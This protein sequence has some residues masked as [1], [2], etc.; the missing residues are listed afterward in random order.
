MNVKKYMSKKIIFLSGPMRGIQRGEG[1]AWRK[2]IIS[3]LGDNFIVLHAYR[4]RE[5]KETFP[6]PRGAIVRDKQD[7]RRCDVVIVNDTLDHVSMIGTSMEVFFA[8]SLDKPVIIF[9]RAH[10]ND[11]WL[12]A[13]SHV[14]V[15]TL[16]EACELIRRLFKD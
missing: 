16:E 6:D 2:E 1:I 13:H 10:E 11:Y 14:R 5:E 9:G 3:I 12:N 15:E 4:G 7:I 8:H